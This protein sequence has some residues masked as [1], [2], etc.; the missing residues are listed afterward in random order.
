MPRPR[1]PRRR[2][3]LVLWWHAQAPNARIFP[4]SKRDEAER[5]ARAENG[6]VVQVVGLVGS[7]VRD[8]WRRD[9]LLCVKEGRHEPSD[10]PPADCGVAI[11]FA[12]RDAK[13]ERRW[14]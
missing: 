8:F 13:A 1:P 6:V 7:D 12:W 3:V 2:R 10:N 4:Y 9:H 14:R 5:L 11:P